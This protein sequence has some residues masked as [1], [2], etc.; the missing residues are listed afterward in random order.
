MIKYLSKVLYALSGS[1]KHLF[2]L[3]LTF[4]LTSVLEA[5]GIGLIGPFITVASEPE[6]ILQN[7]W[8]NGIYSQLNIRSPEQ[9]IALL[10]LAIAIVF[11][12]KS[13]IYFL[14]RTYIIKFSF[15]QKG[16]LCTRLLSAYLSAPYTFHTNKNTSTLIN[17]IVVET[18]KFCNQCLLQLLQAISNLVVTI[19]LLILLLRTSALFLGLLLLTFLPL[20][21]IF[22]FVG[23]R[24]RVWGKRTSESQKEIIKIINH[25]LGGFKETRVIGCEPY[26]QKQMIKQTQILEDSATLFQSSQL[27]PR[28]MLETA[29]VISIVFFVSAFALRDLEQDLTSVLGVFAVASIRLIPSTSQFFQA[30]GNL[31]VSAYALDMLCFDLK[32]IEKLDAERELNLKSG[33][34]RNSSHLYRSQT[35]FFSNEIELHRITYRYPQA[36]EAAVKDISLK[37]NKGESIALI[38]KSGAGKTTLVD[39]ILGLLEPE[40]G[41]IRVDGVSIYQRLRAWQNLVGYIPQSIFLTDDTI[42]G[43]IAFGVAS[44]L[45]DQKRLEG[46]IRAAQL[47][48]LVRQLPDGV[49][50]Y[51]GERGVR[52]SGG[53]RQRIGIARALYHEREILVLDEAT[54][55]LDNETENLVT[56]AIQALSGHKTMIIIAHRLSTIEHCDRIYVMDNGEVVQVGSYE[57]VVA[58]KV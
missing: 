52:L 33:M 43:N 18:N 35:M 48:D 10:G 44:E 20:V 58:E 28:I 2:F 47:D 24:T 42:E 9:F 5:L 8:L 49:K 32:E 16:R 26:F 50:T 17:N 56:E 22:Q 46:A 31:Q 30:I 1:R 37:I 25:S 12:L 38:G 14:A 13:L 34:D 7:E 3:M 11:V 45:V 41:D 27:L 40:R 55:A 6:Y 29:L 23:K 36:D 51:V 53:Q 57:E 39:V 19:V 54:S 15:D 21:L 4:I